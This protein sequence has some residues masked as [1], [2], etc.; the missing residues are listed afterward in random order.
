MIKLD[1]IEWF[2]LLFS[3][4]HRRMGTDA[5]TCTGRTHQFDGVQCLRTSTDLLFRANSFNA[6]DTEGWTL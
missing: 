2:D 4:L 5:Q 1:R 6:N 3:N